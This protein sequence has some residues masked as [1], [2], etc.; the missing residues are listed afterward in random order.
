MP[1]G[2]F[3]I[4]T[5]YNEGPSITGLLTELNEILRRQEEKFTVV[6]VDDAS[7]DNSCELISRF[8]FSGLNLSMKLL[9]LDFNG[10]HQEAIAQG[11][12]FAAV[13]E[14]GHVIVMDGDGEDDPSAIPELMKLRQYDIV[15]VTR[16]RRGNR[17][18]FLLSYFIY[19]LLFRLVTGKRMNFGNYC[20]ISPRVLSI[21]NSR[22]FIHLA[23]FLSKLRLPS[24]SIVADRRKRIS[25]S[26]KMS[27]TS[28]V[29]HAFKS[30][31]EYAEELL[32]VFLRLSV[33]PFPHS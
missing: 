29:H 23:A 15:T 7:T 19:R 9:S 28:L 4:V 8:E 30:F 10:G 5:C 2:T 11:L 18:F 22:S 17:P 25:G 20:M 14:A 27:L 32:M 13:S 33:F 1:E 6:I 16:G 12:H 26:S 31:V 3:I 24:A 21:L